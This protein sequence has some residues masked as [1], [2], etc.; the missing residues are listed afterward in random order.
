LPTEE[1]VVGKDTMPGN[2]RVRGLSKEDRDGKCHRKDVQGSD[3]GLSWPEGAAVVK[4]GKPR[5]K[6]DQTANL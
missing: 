2:A 3:L 1:V 6:Q 5:G 4:S